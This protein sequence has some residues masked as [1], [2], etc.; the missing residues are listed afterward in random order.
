MS[1]GLKLLKAILAN[2]STEKLRDID[3][4]IFIPGREREAY[5]YVVSHYRDYSALP[6][7]GTLEDHM[8][9]DFP[10][11]LEPADFYLNRCLDRELFGNVREPFQSL[12]AAVRNRD[13]NSILASTAALNYACSH[14]REAG[15]VTELSDA[16]ERVMDH[17]DE[18]LAL[19]GGLIGVPTGWSS[20][21]TETLGW[22]KGD[23]VIFV[24][25]P[26]M[27]KTNY[28]LHSCRAAWSSGKSVLFASMEMSSQQIMFR[29]IAQCAG[30]NPVNFRKGE[31]CFWA[32]QRVDRVVEEMQ[33]DRGFHLYEGA[34]KGKSPEQVQNVIQEYSP[35][36]V[37]VD[38]LYLMNSEVAPRNVNRYEKVAYVVDGLKS[39][40]LKRNV[41]VIGTTQFNRQAGSNGRAGSLENLGY[42]D[43]LGTHASI[44]ISVRNPP[45]DNDRHP[46]T[47]VLDFL[48]GREG[49]RGSVLASH[50]FAPLCFDEV[51]ETPEQVAA[52]EALEE[53]QEEQ[54]RR[55]AQGGGNQSGGDQRP[56]G[57]GA[58]TGFMTGN[59]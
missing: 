42:T 43:T 13:T 40:A 20:V 51:G 15:G 27:G 24:A 11:A 55:D 29:L 9:M 7:I 38:G 37:Y 35:D 32:K 47:R 59:S 17:Y 21:D 52:R 16:S 8:E 12:Q 34:F 33:Q 39:A 1:E 54:E 56:R 23:L 4:N 3:E 25:R 30:I 10:A 28:L 46:K 31:L 36:A 6:N 19:D 18:M 48:K 45:G 53:E 49:E 44:I 57:N 22:Q 50:T 41:P 14:A 58:T 26:A 2:N 5:H